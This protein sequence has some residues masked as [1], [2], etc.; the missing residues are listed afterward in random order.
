MWVVYKRRLL[1]Q[2]RDILVSDWL[3]AV[4]NQS[5]YFDDAALGAS[6]REQTFTFVNLGAVSV[7]EPTLA[8]LLTFYVSCDCTFTT[9]PNVNVC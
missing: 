3:R 2:S 5:V 9:V 1:L 7:L 6:V 8:M 4:V